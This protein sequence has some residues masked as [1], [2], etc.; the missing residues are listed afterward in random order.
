MSGRLGAVLAGL[1]AFVVFWLT[2]HQVSVFRWD[3][4]FLA[5][6][7]LHGRTWVE[8]PLPGAVDTVTVGGHVYVPFAPLPAVLF[9]PL[10]A[11]FGVLPLLPWEPTINAALAAT[12]AGLAWSLIARFDG[13]NLRTRIWLTAFFAFSTALWSITVRGGVWHTGQLVATVVTLLGLL[14]STG[15]RRPW[16][17]GLVA[18]AGFLAR[19]PLLFAIPFYAWIAA[20]GEQADGWRMGSG[21]AWGRAAMVIGLA[22]VA[23]VLAGAYNAVRFGS[24]LE[25]GYALAELPSALA[26]T[27]D[28]GLF[29]LAYLPRNLDLLLWHLP[30]TAAPPLFL[31]PDGYGLSIFITSPAIVMIGWADYRRPFILACGLTAFAVLVPS[32]LYYGGGWLQVG[33]RYFFDSMPFVLVLMAAGWKR[34]MATLWKVLIAFGIAV[35]VWGVIFTYLSVL[36]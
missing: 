26:G 28:Q 27:R 1:Y 23:V 33:F 21:P 17:L 5:D 12:S 9:T 35:G 30:V 24:P 36:S 15:P 29:S 3:F 18:G 10:V 20:S 32:L 19:A 2:A 31:L 7:F 34:E 4:Y 13:G 22:G 8:Y 16:V 6:A 11:V 25:S 14:E